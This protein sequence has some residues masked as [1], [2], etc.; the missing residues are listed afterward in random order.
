MDYIQ[1]WCPS[2]PGGKVWVRNTR[3]NRRKT[4]AS[5]RQ[6]I[7]KDRTRESMINGY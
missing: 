7:N 5:L 6:S 2:S 1:L 4:F 3:W